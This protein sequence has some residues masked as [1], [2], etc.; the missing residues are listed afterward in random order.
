MPA[1]P[2]I[3]LGTRPEIIKMAPIAHELSHRNLPFRLIHTGQHYSRNMSE[4]FLRELAMPPLDR[5]LDIGK[6]TPSQ[7]LARCLSALEKTFLKDPPSA[8]LVEGDTNT[9]LAG[10]LSGSKLNIP[11]VHVEAGL[12]SYDLRMPEEHNRKVTDHLSSLLLAPTKNNARTLRDEHVHGKIHVTGNTVIDA[13]LRNMPVALKKSRIMDDLD[14][15]QDS[16][17]LATV[18]RAENV[19]DPKVLSNFIEVFEHSPQPVLLPLHPRTVKNA[20]RFGLWKRLSTS[21]NIKVIDPV[22]Y[23]DF[24]VLMKNCSFILTDSGGIQEECTS[25]NI[26][27]KCF[28]LRKST[29]RQEAVEANFAELVGVRPDGILKAVRNWWEKGARVPKGKSPFGDGKAAEKSVKLLQKAR[30]C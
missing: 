23:W 25:P 11:V 16:Y 15:A 27:R 13:C 6:G 28:V 7:Q 30:Y 2:A 20:R 10:A 14:L 18:H 9:V 24:L 5:F 3:I 22:G 19:D 29:E 26:R 1:P 17:A 4:I 8:I 12:R 21:N